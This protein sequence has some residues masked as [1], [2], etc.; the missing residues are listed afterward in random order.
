VNK[1]ADMI[2]LHMMKALEMNLKDTKAYH[3]EWI[4]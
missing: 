2:Y 1:S 3:I 4:N